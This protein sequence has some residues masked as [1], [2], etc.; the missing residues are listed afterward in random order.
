MRHDPKKLSPPPLGWQQLE[1]AA[2]KRAAEAASAMAE[3]V[4]VMMEMAA[5]AGV[6]P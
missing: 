5:V 4:A 1:S 3:A 6:E 2:E